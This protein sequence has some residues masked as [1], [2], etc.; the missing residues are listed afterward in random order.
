[1]TLRCFVC[2][3]DCTA[4][5][6]QVWQRAGHSDEVGGLD[7]PPID[8]VVGV[9]D[10]WRADATFHDLC[11]P[12]AFDLGLTK[13]PAAPCSICSGTGLRVGVRYVCEFSRE[14]HLDGG[15]YRHCSDCE[16]I[17]AL[18]PCPRIDQGGHPGKAEIVALAAARATLDEVGMTTRDL[19]IRAYLAG[20]FNVEE[21]D[22]NGDRIVPNDA[23]REEAATAVDRILADVEAVSAGDG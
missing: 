4:D 18:V 15:T 7:L 23:D 1:M 10:R 3:V 22:A 2:D 6:V 14:I 9:G 8:V 12:C 5:A 20:I 17:G 21:Y 19:M 11:R 16:P 13:T